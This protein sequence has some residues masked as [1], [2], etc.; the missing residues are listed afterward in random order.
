MDED[1]ENY[2]NYPYDDGY[3]KHEKSNID[4]LY[5]GKFEDIKNVST[6]ENHNPNS[7]RLENNIYN[8]NQILNG[9][10]N[11]Y[12]NLDNIIN[13]E[14]N[15]DNKNLINEPPSINSDIFHYRTEQPNLNRATSTSHYNTV[16]GRQII[17]TNDIMT[18]KFQEMFKN[19]DI[20]IDKITDMQFLRKKKKRRK[21]NEILKEQI[22]TKGIK[23]SKKKG[24]I[25]REAKI[26]GKIK[27]NHP[28][29]SDDN[30][31]KKINTFLIEEIR[32]W[33]N[34]SFLDD[35]FTDF[36]TEKFRTKKKKGIFMKLSP[37]SENL[38]STKIKKE[39]ILKT[40]DTKFKE[41]FR[42]NTISSKYKNPNPDNNKELINKI[43]E[44]KSQDFVMFILEMTFYE[45]LNF[46]NGQIPNEN[47]IQYFRDNYK[48]ND[49][50]INKFI[51]NFGK[52]GK[53]YDKLL[54]NNDKSIEETKTYFS[55]INV[56]CLNY[57]NSFMDKYS[58]KDKEKE[59]D[60]NEP[61]KEKSNGV[62]TPEE[63]NG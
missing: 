28:K 25:K 32:K 49:T 63:L 36:Q 60:K 13:I 58:R 4:L 47:I 14:K 16:N 26:S 11:I 45:G 55:K 43:Y 34:S 10:S 39:L 6:G 54:K 52:I 33:L 42:D 56:L 7:L 18:N 31:I 17:T 46:F 22:F 61:E 27:V 5:E 24:R 15:S 37:K 9:Q 2:I 41:I 57:K 50:L 59:K 1:G 19:P 29:E 53:L 44:E 21:K 30:I 23:L 51:N 8:E 3:F 20:N 62:G 48:Y 35:N 38:I 12:N 40:L